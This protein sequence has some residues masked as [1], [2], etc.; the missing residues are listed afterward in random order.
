[1]SAAMWVYTD[2]VDSFLSI[3]SK[4]S[5]DE[6]WKWRKGNRKSLARKR[7]DKEMNWFVAHQTLRTKPVIPMK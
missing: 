3:I 7:T 6:Y 1:M 5:N 2:S 4:Y